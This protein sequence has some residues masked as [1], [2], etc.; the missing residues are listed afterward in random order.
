M[1]SD[2]N[3]M[4]LSINCKL[5]IVNKTVIDFFIIVFV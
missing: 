5:I 4:N 2:C 3:K 1:K